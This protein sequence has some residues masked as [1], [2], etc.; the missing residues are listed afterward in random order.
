MKEIWKII[1]SLQ[2]YYKV[3]NFGN[4][5]RSE[6]NRILTQRLDNYGYNVVHIRIKDIKKNTQC[7][8]HRLVAEAFIHNP[9]NKPQV[10]HIDGDKTNNF[11]NNLEWCTPSEN[12][13]HKYNCLGYK[14]TPHHCKKILCVETGEVFNSIASARRKI[15]VSK[16]FF[17]KVLSNKYPNKKTAKGYHWK[18]V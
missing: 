11:V 2:G 10:N 6:S 18:V 7:K 15:G 13:Y 17:S 8:V 16:S 12:M 1:P 9:D 3:S 4:I 5:M 14:G